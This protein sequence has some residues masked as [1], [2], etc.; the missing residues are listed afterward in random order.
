MDKRRVID[1]WAANQANPDAFGSAVYWLANDLVRE[2]H[3][4]RGTR[5]KYPGWA[6]YCLMEFLADRL[7]VERMLSLG[8]GRGELER[9]PF[10]MGAFEHCL[11]IDLTPA[12]VETARADCEAAGIGKIEY[13]VADI[14]RVELA[15]SAFDAAWFNGSLHH[16]SE[17][18]AVLAN[19]A[20]ALKP[21][22]FLFM[23]E[24]VGPSRFDFGARQREAMR[25][26]FGLI[27]ERYRRCH[28]PRYPHEFKQEVAFPDPKN[29]AQADPSEAVR[30]SD[31][32][33][34]LEKSFEIV[35]KNDQ[36]GT[37]LQFLLSG[38]AG[39]FTAEDPASVEVLEL[40]FQVE[41]T[42]IATGDL[43]SD[44]AVV[45]ARPRAALTRI[46][47]PGEV[48]QVDQRRGESSVR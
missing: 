10:R 32:L 37:L 20:R 21:G 44:F 34:V 1:R 7:P 39:N 12:S 8:C 16:I 36:G 14:E 22:G 25:A 31:I 38:I 40:L 27:P 17:L 28:I 18:E 26:A 3:Q 35:E 9:N 4:R 30:S 41:D 6:R 13:Q 29:V 46:R 15:P 48:D 24:Y 5:G 11:A 43:E 42:L 23:Q 33:A 47:N 19:V 2:R 45:V